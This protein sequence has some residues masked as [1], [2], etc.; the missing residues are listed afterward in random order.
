M[1]IFFFSHILVKSLQSLSFYVTQILIFK[2]AKSEIWGATAAKQYWSI[3]AQLW[4]NKKYLLAQFLKLANLTLI[5]NL[6]LCILNTTFWY[7]IHHWTS[8]QFLPQISPWTLKLVKNME[9]SFFFWT[10]FFLS[11]KK[12][13]SK[14]KLWVERQRFFHT[15]RITK[16]LVKLFKGLI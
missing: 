2:N 1:D 8:T 4:A 15:F 10:F 16:T 13:H 11:N 9:Y 12:N 3:V 5:K 7:L 6:I 14:E